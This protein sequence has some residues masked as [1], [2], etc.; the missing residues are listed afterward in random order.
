M[1]ALLQLSPYAL[2]QKIKMASTK[3]EKREYWTALILRSFL[4]IAFAII[5]I[6]LFTKIFGTDN[7]SVAVASFC[8]LLGIRFVSYGY[9]F[10][11]HLGAL[12][13][14]LVLFLFGS[15]AASTPNSWFHFGANLLNLFFL[16]R[17][18]S[19]EPQLGNAG[20]YVFSYLFISQ[21]PVIGT[22]LILRFWS[23]VAVFIICGAV[24]WQKHRNKKET[25]YL[26]ELLRGIDPSQLLDAWQLRLA[27]GVSGAVLIGELFGFP[28]VVWIGYASMSVLLPYDRELK[29]RA[30]ERVSGVFLGSVLF[31]VIFLFL[32]EEYTAFIGPVA[33]FCLGLSGTYFWNTVLNCFGALLL[34]GSLYG[35][36]PAVF[37]RIENNLIGA[38]F[39]FAFALLLER[40]FLQEMEKEQ[41]ND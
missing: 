17:L 27:I 16:L 7:S 39:A 13:L 15:L 33:G 19:N 30:L 18:T 28:R 25:F 32:N 21:T 26:K 6:S 24:I 2:K 23:L 3:K 4:L 9:R 10:V 20:I 22:S 31:G 29:R 41:A 34:A 5:Y 38:L 1:Y 37:Y 40:I 12:A 11:E 14:V 36:G 8:M 35:T